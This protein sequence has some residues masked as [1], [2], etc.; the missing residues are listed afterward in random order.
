M[1]HS[2]SQSDFDWH[3]GQSASRGILL[4]GA[5]LGLFAAIFV[6]PFVM[7]G[8]QAIGEF[9]LS[10]IAVW[11]TSF[12]LLHH[13]LQR[14]QPWR[15]TGIEPLLLAGIALCVTQTV[16]LTPEVLNSLSPQLERLLPLWHSSAETPPVVELVPGRWST[17]SLVPMATL[18]STCSVISVV[19]LFLVAAQRVDTTSDATL[20]MRA[21][22]VAATLMAIFGCGQF[23]LGNGKF[24]GFYEHPF[25]HTRDYAKGAFTN[26]NHFADYLAMSVPILLAWY[27]VHT[28][29]SQHRRRSPYDTGRDHLAR[30][31]G[32]I[33]LVCLA[34]VSIGILLSQ[35]RGGLVTASVGAIVTLFLLYR[36]QLLTMKAAGSIGGIAIAALVSLTLFGSHIESLIEANFHEL[37][38]GDAEQLDHGSARQKIWNAAADG[39]AQYPLMGT[40][41]S[42]HREV[43]WTYFDH[44]DITGEFSHAESGYMQL[45]LETGFIGAGIAAM[46]LLLVGFWCVRGLSQPISGEAAALTAAIVGVFV[47]NLVH[48]I[49]DFVWYVPSIMTVLVLIAA[50]AARLADIA[51]WE[52]L[53]GSPRSSFLARFGGIVTACGV[54]ALGV[55]MAENQLPTLVAEPHWHE[56]IRLVNEEATLD[57]DADHE[58]IQSRQLAALTQAARLDPHDCRIQMRAAAAVLTA[59][60]DQR[61]DDPALM[62]LANLRDAAHASEWESPEQ[63]QQWLNNPS[64]LGDR[65]QLDE[66]WQRTQRALSLCPLLA[67]GYISLGELAW[68]HGAGQQQ[69]D[70]LLRQALITRPYDP[71]VH[72]AA[73]REAWLRGME[74]AAVA[75]WKRAFNRDGKYQQL[76]INLLAEGMPASFFLENFDPD[77]AAISRLR[78]AYRKTQDQESFKQLSVLLTQRL[79]VDAE[80]S[81]LGESFPLWKQAHETF[82]EMGDEAGARMTAQAAVKAN[83]N[84]LPARLL[85]GQWLYRHDEFAAAR[86]HLEFAAQRRR[87][88]KSLQKMVEVAGRM[89]ADTRGHR[90]VAETLR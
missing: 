53:P 26:P 44:P 61:R 12:W 37:V 31:S 24:F 35:S 82:V 11:T 32:V 55:W 38:S 49:T 43:Y 48:S 30:L 58:P 5:D 69:E 27:A 29:S 71:L 85:L 72:F 47:V 22:A 73:G 33:V 65:E 17:L 78:D 64:V 84:S 79:I 2:A 77:T 8:R 28:S 70:D 4:W 59:Y 39:I 66:A 23:L 51:T 41:L 3:S 88:D 9:T 42:S 45:P 25:T 54:M 36:Q 83:P 68:L 67:E 63:L 90:G 87:H 6:L 14:D 20:L 76:I 75:H 89:S 74:P 7:G 18:R 34:C 52:Q 62:S 80:S 10:V 15:F 1:S 19:M 81:S 13:A 21:F 16:A 46:A 86:E 57:K 60:R 40:G 56:Y 50:C